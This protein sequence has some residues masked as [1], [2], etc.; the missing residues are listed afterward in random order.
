MKVDE[1]KVY[2]DDAPINTIIRFYRQNEDVVF[3]IIKGDQMQTFFFNVHGI[4]E[5]I[6]HSLG[7]NKIN[8][9]ANLFEVDIFIDDTD[10]TN[11]FLE[12]Y[13]IILED[14]GNKLSLMLKNDIL[15]I[16]EINIPIHFFNK[17]K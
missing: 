5:L 3:D 6:N 7:I 11:L 2:A 4:S 14:N 10:T 8:K 9:I 16:N 13:D 15:K 12:R 17:L 1:I